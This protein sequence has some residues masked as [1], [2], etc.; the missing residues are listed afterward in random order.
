MMPSGAPAVQMVCVCVE[1][2]P[3]TCIVELCCFCLCL[4]EWQRKLDVLCWVEHN[5]RC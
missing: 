4:M 2:T 5:C 3:N 1:H